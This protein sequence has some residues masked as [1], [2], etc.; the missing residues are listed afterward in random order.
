[1]ATT[2]VPAP[3]TRARPRLDFFAAQASARRRTELLLLLF[4]LALLGISYLVYLAFHQYSHGH[5]LGTGAHPFHADMYAQVAFLTALALG[6]G[7]VY[8]MWRLRHGGGAVAALVGG[9]AVDPATRDPLERRLLNIVEEMA[10]ASGAPVPAVYLLD[11]ENAINAFAAGL[12]LHNAVIAVT[13]GALDRLNRDELQGVV[14]HEFSHILNGDMRLNVR[15][16]GVLYGLLFLAL[17]GR[18]LAQRPLGRLTRSSPLALL[19]VGLALVG[20][21]GVLVGRIIKLAVT[22]QREHL[23]DAAAV[24]FTRNPAG[25]AG[26]LKKVGAMFVG[27]RITHPAAEELSHMYFVE[28]ATLMTMVHTHPPLL[29]R[30][31]RLDPAFDGDF[32]RHQTR[33]GEQQEPMGVDA[34]FRPR[35]G[36][37][38]GPAA[39]GRQAPGELLAALLSRSIGAPAPEHIAY[40]AGLLDSLPETLKSAVHTGE[41]AQAVVCALLRE[42]DPAVAATQRELERRYGGAAFPQH[43]ETLLP[44]LRGQDESAR[45]PLLDLALPALRTLPEERARAFQSLVDALV[46]ADRRVRIFELALT[47]VLARQLAGRKERP[48]A[49]GPGP[50]LRVHLSAILSAVARAGVREEKEV[51]AAFEAGAARLHESLGRLELLPAAAIGFESLDAALARVETVS[52]ALRGKLLEACAFCAG[53]DGLVRA[54]EAEFLRAIAETLDCP[55]PPPLPRPVPV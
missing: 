47:R 42:A 11:N 27:A 43:V 36:V 33:V 20:Y 51:R 21:L 19:G 13:R 41:G 46:R 53:Q 23:A 35:P 2:T 8:G 26:A 5:T 30:I 16:I 9:R 38:P 29:Q 28:S 10:I 40:A 15:L 37:E 1:M 44:L 32:S 25:L 24:Q 54:S 48:S 12:S 6:G 4:G 39:A 14:A 34:E 45:L 7:S 49:A 22:R 17:I 31:R 50:P 3:T 55:V 18:I 52:L